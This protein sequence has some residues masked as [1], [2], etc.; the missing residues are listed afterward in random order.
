VGFEEYPV[1]ASEL[2]NGGDQTLS[3]AGLRQLLLKC[4][5]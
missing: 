4:R 2:P 5:P 1:E 3:F